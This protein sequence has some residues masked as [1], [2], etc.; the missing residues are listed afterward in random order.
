MRGELAVF[1]DKISTHSLTRR[2]T[3]E[4][5]ALYH[6]NIISTHSLTRRLTGS[7]KLLS[8][9]FCIS[10]HSLTRRLT[11]SHAPYDITVSFQLTASQG[12]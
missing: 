2:L 3:T 4:R 9:L 10:T 7:E 1:Y 6:A 12:G 8:E 11:V 5:S